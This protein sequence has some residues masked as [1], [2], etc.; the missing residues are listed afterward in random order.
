MSPKTLRS[1][2]CILNGT[3]KNHHKN[4]MR[5]TA[6]FI[7]KKNTKYDFNN[8]MPRM[9]FSTKSVQNVNNSYKSPRK[10]SQTNLLSRSAS[11]QLIISEA[12]SDSE[13]Y[14]DMYNHFNIK[15]F[16]SDPYNHFD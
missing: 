10:L 4:Y 12:D 1:R 16:G 6:S 8:T 2:S 3:R 15:S 5:E 9:S 13:N 11:Q 14:N 7:S